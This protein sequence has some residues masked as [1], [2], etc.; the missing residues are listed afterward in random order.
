MLGIAADK[1]SP[2]MQLFER[3]RGLAIEARE[4][5]IDNGDDRQDAKRI[6]RF[7]RHNQS[8]HYVY[9]HII[10]VLLSSNLLVLQHLECPKLLRSQHI[11]GRGSF[12]RINHQHQTK[13]VPQLLWY[14]HLSGLLFKGGYRL[15]NRLL[16]TE[17]HSK[18]DRGFEGSTLNLVRRGD[19]PVREEPFDLRHTPSPKSPTLAMIQPVSMPE[20]RMFAG[21]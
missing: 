8:S 1:A 9:I 13:K 18:F 21:L 12:A 19:M 15:R 10:D 4:A 14:L 16:F 7:S 6:R 20:S 17:A 11:Q 2:G 5:G 3:L